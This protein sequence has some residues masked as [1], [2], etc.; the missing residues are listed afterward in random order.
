[1][2][3]LN[4]LSINKLSNHDLNIS[5]SVPSS[6]LIYR[7]HICMR[8]INGDNDNSNKMSNGSLLYEHDDV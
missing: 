6:T 3:D 2:F 8:Y 5:M 4:V 7:Y 1:M